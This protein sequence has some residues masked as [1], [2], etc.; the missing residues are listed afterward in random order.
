MPKQQD[1][2]KGYLIEKEKLNALEAV[3]Y[4][5]V[6]KLKWKLLRSLFAKNGKKEL[7]SSSFA[8][9]FNNNAHWLVSY[10]VFSYLRELHGSIDFNAW[11]THS[12]YNEVAIQKWQ[13]H[14][15]LFIQK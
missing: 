11:P 2:I 12:I 6:M 1:L 13:I 8:E 4:E 9:F 10:S 15:P 7:T 3:D 5:L 14:L